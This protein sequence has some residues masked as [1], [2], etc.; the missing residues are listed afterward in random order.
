MCSCGQPFRPRRVTI[1]TPRLRCASLEF[2]A[3]RVAIIDTY[4]PAFL[5][6]H[7][8]RRS[9]LQECPYE[10]QLSA[11]MERCFGTAD[12]YSQNLRDQGHEAI[13]LVVN[14]EP[15]QRAWAREHGRSLWHGRVARAL[16]SL[17]GQAAS[18]VLLRRLAAAQVEAFQ[19]DVV[20]VQDLWFFRRNELEALKTR[21]ALLV[22]QC[23]SRLPTDNRLSSFDL[24]TTSFPHLVERLRV[25][26]IDSEYLRIAFD[27]RVLARLRGLGVRSEAESR[28]ALGVVF[29]GGIHAPSDHRAGTEFLEHLCAELPIEVWGYVKDQL[30]RDSPIRRRHRG[31]AWGLDMYRVLANARIAINRHGDIAEGHANNMRLFEATGVGALLMT[32]AAPNL[33]ELFEPGREIVAYEN[34][35][36]L[37]EK[38][39]FYLE[40]DQERRAVAVAGQR[41]TL[42]EHTYRLRIR[43]LTALL[44]ARLG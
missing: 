13:D 3:V 18:S 15:L 1:A 28:R 16:P 11:L 12:A 43:E 4:Y 9:G 33:Q 30:K 31:E 32:E 34:T 23:G 14:C 22:G 39:R 27:E 40:Q 42:S 5:A 38:A 35:D 21:G 37:I 2:A 41:R 19:P 26:G 6:D 8:T 36:D 29:V 25:Q 20:Y 44:E 24:L 7:Y 17:A 10:Q